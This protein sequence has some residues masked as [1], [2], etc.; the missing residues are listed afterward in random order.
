MT[1]TVKYP[2]IIIPKSAANGYGGLRKIGSNHGDLSMRSNEL[3]AVDEAISKVGS[4]RSKGMVVYK[5]VFLVAPELPPVTVKD[6]EIEEV[7]P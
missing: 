4:N 5:A 1:Q 2:Y 6:I 3:S 7:S